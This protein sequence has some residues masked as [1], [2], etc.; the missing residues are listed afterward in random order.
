[1]AN[2]MPMDQSHSVRTLTIC[3]ARH[4]LVAV[5]FFNQVL[6]EIQTESVIKI[7]S[8]LNKNIPNVQQ[9]NVQKNLE[10][11]KSMNSPIRLILIRPNCSAKKTAF[12]VWFVQTVH[13][14]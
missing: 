3:F 5:A 10:S 6:L 13:D 11:L 1:M 14:Q 8:V 12:W 4:V 7:D 2:T 9:K